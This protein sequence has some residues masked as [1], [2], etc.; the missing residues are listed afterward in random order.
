LCTPEN[1]RRFREWM[2]NHLNEDG[3]ILHYYN[4][5]TGEEMDSSD[6]NTDAFPYGWVQ[7]NIIV[8]PVY[9]SRPDDVYV[10]METIWMGKPTQGQ[11]VLQVVLSFMEDYAR[12]MGLKGSHVLHIQN[13]GIAKV[14][15]KR[16]YCVYR[17]GGGHTHGPQSDDVEV[18]RFINTYDPRTMLNKTGMTVREFIAA[19]Q[20]VLQ[21]FGNLLEGTLDVR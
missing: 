9:R 18:L 7:L 6:M 11:G 4:I 5:E 8:A 12:L 14:L 16:G 1:V 21:P 17:E 2:A 3:A 10:G 20:E 15:R 19:S 13:V